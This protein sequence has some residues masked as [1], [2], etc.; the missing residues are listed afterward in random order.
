MK[1]SKHRLRSLSLV[2]L[3]SGAATLAIGCFAE[4]NEREFL[5]QTKAGIPSEFPNEKVSERRAR[6]KNQTAIDRRLE[7]KAK[8]KA[9]KKASAG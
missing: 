8:A 6:L 2:V 4:N 7:Q 9:E 1:T 5:K 3:M